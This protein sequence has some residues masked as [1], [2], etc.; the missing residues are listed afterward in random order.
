VI[1]YFFSVFICVAALVFV[2]V[3]IVGTIDENDRA[4]KDTPLRV[5]RLACHLLMICLGVAWIATTI[6]WWAT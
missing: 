3:G 2:V 4:N 5:W 6:R 1:E